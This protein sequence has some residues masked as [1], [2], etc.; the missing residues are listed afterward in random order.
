MPNRRSSPRPR[1]ALFVEFLAGGRRWAAVTRDISRRGLFILSANP[2]RKGERLSVALHI[3][4]GQKVSL[5]GR[6]GVQRAVPYSRSV[7]ASTGF[8][9]E[10][11]ACPVEY[12]AYLSAVSRTRPA[13]LARA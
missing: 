13:P 2:P 5:E 12:E 8:I 9:F 6:A 1:K 11:S 7:S 10:F 3:G 4:H